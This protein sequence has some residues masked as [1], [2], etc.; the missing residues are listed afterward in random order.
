MVEATRTQATSSKRLHYS[1]PEKRLTHCRD[2]NNSFA[3]ESKYIQN[4]FLKKDS[5]EHARMHQEENLNHVFVNRTLNFRRLKAVGFDMDH[6]LIRYNSHA[7]EELTFQFI[8]DILI[9]RLG[10]PEEVAS[11]KFKYDLAIRGLVIDQKNGAL[12]KLDRFNQIYMSCQGTRIIPFKEQRL[13]YS[14]RMVDL[15]DPRFLSIDTTFSISVASMY[16]QLV[17]LK[18]S[19]LELPE[20]DQMAQDTLRAVD[21]AHGE[22]PLKDFVSENLTRF[23]QKD[24]EVVRGLERLKKHGKFLFII[25]NSDY[26][27]AKALLDFAINPFLE[28]HAHWSELFNLVLVG[29]QK[30]R[31]FQDSLRLLKVD[32]HNGSLSN[33]FGP[34]TEG[35]FQ[36]GSAERFET[37]FGFSPQDIL[38]MGDHIYGDILRLKKD[39]GWRTGLVLEELSQEIESL[40]QTQE[41][42]ADI[43]HWMK[44]KLPLERRIQELE[45]QQIEGSHHGHSDEISLLFKEMKVID[46]K[47]SQLIQATSKF[48]NPT[49]GPIMRSG[50]ME[51]YYANQVVRF[52]DL[53]MDRLSALMT[54]SPRAYF[55][56]SRIDLPHEDSDL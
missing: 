54:S 17:D 10:Y 18:C 29:A 22:G 41:Q 14:D 6:T 49:W 51:S 21:L 33:H 30:P 42:Q 9:T 53:Y 44:K 34:L 55:R 40:K 46:Q 24:P 39:C 25:T 37:S 3:F 43:D 1:N 48:Y 13:N 11:T 45:S 8:R 52:A 5:F 2:L 50:N 26:E 4:P 7:F 20:Y 27:Y 36:G 16:M 56:A 35:L 15:S 32:P 38:Y 47:L 23:I 12:L 19:G 31:F 28:N